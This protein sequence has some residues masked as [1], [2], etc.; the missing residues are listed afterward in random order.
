MMKCTIAGIQ[1]S[2]GSLLRPRYLVIRSKVLEND[3]LS[4]KA[5]KYLTSEK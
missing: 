2:K 5:P 1:L 3:N 4:R